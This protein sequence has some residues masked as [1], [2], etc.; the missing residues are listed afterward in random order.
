MFNKKS[1]LDFIETIMKKFTSYL[2]ILSKYDAGWVNEPDR[3]TKTERES[4]D[5]RPSAIYYD[6]DAHSMNTKQVASPHV[7]TEAPGVH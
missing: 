7:F 2:F 1:R 5:G 3:A 4:K 6:E